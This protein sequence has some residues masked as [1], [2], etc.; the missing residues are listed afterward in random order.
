MASTG[1]YAR[2]DDTI[3]SQKYPEDVDDDDDDDLNASK[4]ASRRRR[5]YNN[6]SCGYTCLWLWV[7][8]LAMSTFIL[9]I[10]LA[11]RTCASP[12]P[13]PVPP[14]PMPVSVAPASPAKRSVSVHRALESALS[15]S[16]DAQ[17][18]LV[19]Y[20]TPRNGP[21]AGK[22]RYV[23]V[24]QTQPVTHIPPRLK[25]AVHP[26]AAAAAAEQSPVHRHRVVDASAAIDAAAHMW[27][28]TKCASGR[29]HRVAYDTLVSRHRDEPLVLFNG[30]A[31]PAFFD[32]V[33]G[34]SMGEHAVLLI[35]E[36]QLVSNATSRLYEVYLNEY[37]TWSTDAAELR[38][39]VIDV[40]TLAAN[41]LGHALS[42]R[43]SDD[44]RSVLSST[45]GG[46]VRQLVSS[47]RVA[48]CKR[49]VGTAND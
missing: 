34:A 49:A 30:W 19:R 14:P 7:F 20:V 46:A 26:M 6:D 11:T 3:Y 10:V 36:M 44:A 13:A 33:L 5:P 43:V 39:G 8:L 22:T 24:A 28:T 38:R 1:R 15:D 21:T 47:D 16:L 48:L 25:Y 9:A 17:Y 45:Y 23:N 41:A 35:V 18:V 40:Q 12:T 32:A 4:E 31:S 42:L 29:L 2:L 37:F 27:N